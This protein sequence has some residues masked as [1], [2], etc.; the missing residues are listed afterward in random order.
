MRKWLEARRA[1]RSKALA[2]RQSRAYK[3]ARAELEQDLYKVARAFEVE[4]RHEGEFIDALADT[5]VEWWMR[6]EEVL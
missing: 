3:Q 1:R 5:A 4:V 2:E 6:W